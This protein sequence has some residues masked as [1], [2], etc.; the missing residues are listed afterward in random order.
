MLFNLTPIRQKSSSKPKKVEKKF[1]APCPA[2]W[3]LSPT[4]CCPYMLYCLRSLRRRAFPVADSLPLPESRL[5]SEKKQFRACFFPGEWYIIGYHFCGAV[6][7]LARAIRSHRIGRGFN[8]HLL[9]HRLSARPL[10]RVFFALFILLLN[11]LC[12]RGLRKQSRDCTNCICPLIYAPKSPKT[13]RFF[14]RF[15]RFSR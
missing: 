3:H 5:F 7:Q 15:L 10:G 4:K 1:R 12:S 11:P 9:H 6:A 2:A 14:L 8:S 13:A